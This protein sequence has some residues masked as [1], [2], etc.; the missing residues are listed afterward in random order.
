MVIFFF[1][2]W[3]QGDSLK[4][5]AMEG[6]VLYRNNPGTAVVAV[7]DAV[8]LLLRLHMHLLIFVLFCWYLHYREQCK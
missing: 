6:T 8:D 1:I 4:V 5:T 3:S 7:A 2:Q